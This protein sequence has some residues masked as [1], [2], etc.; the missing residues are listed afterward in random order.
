MNKKYFLII[1][2]ILLGTLALYAS[3]A[4]E[5]IINL[6]NTQG[7]N[8][9]EPRFWADGDNYYLAWSKW[10]DIQFRRSLDAGETWEP[11]I[12]LYTAFDYGGGYPAVAASD[13]NVYVVYYRNT[14]GDSQIFMCKSHD[15]G[16]TFSNEIQITTAIR[17]A[18]TP[19]ITADGDDVYVVYEDR[20]VDWTY[21]IYLLHSDDAGN[22]WSDPVQISDPTYHSRWARIE[23]DN[24]MLY[25]VWN[26]NVGD[27][28]DDLDIFFSKSA[29]QG[30]TW[31]DPINISNNMAYNA[32]LALAAIDDDIY[33][34]SSAKIDGIQTDIMFYQSY[35]QGETWTDG[36]NLADNPGTSSRPDLFVTSSTNSQNRVYL[37]WSDRTYAPDYQA[38]LR[39]S[40]DNGTTWSDNVLVSQETGDAIWPQMIGSAGEEEDTLYAGWAHAAAGT[41]DYEIYG[42]RGTSDYMNLGFITGTVTDDEGTLLENVSVSAGNYSTTT[43]EEGE[44][45]LSVEAGTYDVFCLNQV[46]EDVTVNAGETVIVD[47]VI[48][49]DPPVLFPPTNLEATV[50]E[51]IVELTWD[52][53]FSN[54]EWKHWDSGENYDAVGGENVPIFDAAI[55]FDINDLADYDQH[56]LTHITAYFEDV[57]C[58]IFIRIWRG[59]SQQYAG[60]LILEFPIVEPEPASWNTITLPTPIL[61]DSSE[62][63]W[64]GYRIINPQGVFPAGIDDG[65]SVPYKG[66][67]LLYGA[68]WVSMA[69]YFGWDVNWNIQGFV[70]P[71]ESEETRPLTKIQSGT[72]EADGMPE[73]KGLKRHPIPA[74]PYEVLG[75]NIYQNDEIIEELYFDP[76]PYL[77]TD[78]PSGVY[79]FYVTAVYEEGESISSNT[80]EVDLTGVQLDEIVASTS[81]NK[82]YPNPFNPET[83]ISYSLSK[84]EYVQIKIYNM[85]GQLVKTLKDGTQEAGQHQIIWNGRDNN[86]NPVAS[87]VYFTS[88]KAGNHVSTKKMILMK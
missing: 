44:Y 8:S 5:E 56:Y 30:S 21:Q 63:L 43:D 75:Y 11:A 37:I 28:Y 12:E 55:R 16:Q 45:T 41:F 83:T 70:T 26:A 81:L 18:I 17:N 2:L 57:N 77:I 78:L 19:M 80:V 10:G 62:E 42:R 38:Y 25:A 76:A 39:Y 79:Q 86:A 46:V 74:N 22:T 40:Y 47:F 4:F 67:L 32:R 82:N 51:N 72:G 69:D 87:G 85:R 60:E 24:D 7:W 59:G 66:D 73:L 53:P 68:Q 54:G 20:D 14:A 58:D 50:D 65:P 52:P 71:Y 88:F 61:I 31:S 13:D 33:I 27:D 15:N 1:T 36:V 49:P 29:D 35:D 9:S 48:T 6:S 3:V 84:E 64:I 23:V 34:A